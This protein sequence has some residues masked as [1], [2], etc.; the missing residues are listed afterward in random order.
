MLAQQGFQ[1]RDD[2]EELSLPWFFMKVGGSSA[3]LHSCF[4]LP[5]SRPVHHYLIRKFLRL[6]HIAGIECRT[7]KSWIEPFIVGVSASCAFASRE[8]DGRGYS[9][10][11]FIALAFAR[12]VQAGEI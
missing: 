2:L 10:F 9:C 6:F 7:K 4:E 3:V 12:V 11:V 5:C 1:L 8:C